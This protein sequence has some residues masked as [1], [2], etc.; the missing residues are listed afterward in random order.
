MVLLKA[1]PEI[2][3]DLVWVENEW[4]KEVDEMMKECCEDTSKDLL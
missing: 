2:A 4:T 1:L 3:E